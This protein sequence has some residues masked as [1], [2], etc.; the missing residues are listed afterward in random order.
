MKCHGVHQITA[1]PICEYSGPSGLGSSGL[2]T[3]CKDE[4]SQQVMRHAAP[5]WSTDA[6][7]AGRDVERVIAWAVRRRVVDDLDH[8]ARRKLVGQVNQ[9][10]ASLATNA[11]SY[12]VHQ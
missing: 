10:T 12:A 4:C 8:D 6:F 3:R 11:R 7:I 9:I 5:V 2:V 1:P